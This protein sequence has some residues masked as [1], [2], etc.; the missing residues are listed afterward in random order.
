MTMQA[1]EARKAVEDLVTG[2]RGVRAA[3]LA[4]VDG[5]PVVSY[6]P[7]H[8]EASTAAIVASSKGLGE[9]LSDLTGAGQLQEIVVRSTSGYTVIYSVGARGVLT[10]LTDS[11]ANL[12]MLHI[13]ARDL[14]GHLS[15]LFA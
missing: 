1:P 5:R 15:A 9:R 11:A 10:V 6:L 7:D 14:A 4:S 8:D 2:T 3:L 12:A 13:K